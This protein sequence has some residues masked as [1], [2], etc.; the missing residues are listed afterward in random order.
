MQYNW[1]TC[2][3]IT[4]FSCSLAVQQIVTTCYVIVKIL[5]TI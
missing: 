3:L 4:G 1:K 5:Y 2:V